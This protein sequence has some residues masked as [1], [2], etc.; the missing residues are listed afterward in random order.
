MDRTKKYQKIAQVLD[1]IGNIWLILVCIVIAIEYIGIIIFQEWGRLWEILSP[2]NVWNF[3]AVVITL[4]PGIG[5]KILA[6]KLRKNK[7]ATHN[8]I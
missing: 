1:W 5:I 4:A 6:N 7:T 8:E 2:F 3:I